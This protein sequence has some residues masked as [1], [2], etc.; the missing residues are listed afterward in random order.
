MPDARFARTGFAQ[1]NFLPDQNFWPAGFMKADGV[2]HGIVPRVR[3][4]KANS[5]PTE[6]VRGSSYDGNMR[7]TSGEE[8]PARGTAASNSAIKYRLVPDIVQHLNRLGVDSSD[9]RRATSG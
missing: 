5:A 7:R 8:Q 4:R 1:F 9:S 2:R 3:W 6:Q